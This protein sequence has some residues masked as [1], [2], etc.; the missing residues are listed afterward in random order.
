VH[1]RLR[2]ARKDLGHGD[3]GRVVAKVGP[4]SAKFSGKVTLSDVNPPNGYR[5]F[6]EGTGG[7]AGFA[8]GGARVT[9]ADEGEATLLSYVVDAQVGGKLAQIGSRLIDATARKMAADFF[10][11]F[12]D[13]VGAAGGYT[14]ASETSVEQ[15]P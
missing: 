15:A 10:A 14:A 3:A 5:I 1:S 9:L 7:P 2:F 11:K 13:I 6:G 4:V 12:A 8:K